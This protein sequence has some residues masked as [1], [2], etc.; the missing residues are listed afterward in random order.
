[1]RLVLLAVLVGATPGCA[2][3]SA[4]SPIQPASLQ[5]AGGWIAVPTVPHL[6]ADR[7]DGGPAALAMLLAYW[8]QPV[9]VAAV[10]SACVATTHSGNTRANDLGGFAANRGFSVFLVSGGLDIIEHEL[11]ARRPV[12]VA[13]VER[14]SLLRYRGRYALVVGY[15]P[16]RRLVATLDAEHGWQEQSIEAFTEVWNPSERLLLLVIPPG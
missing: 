2:G 10:A 16:A 12:V 4:A 5:A 14:Q 8:K 13:L 9:G 3:R 7:G 6:R 1:M 11:A 15:H